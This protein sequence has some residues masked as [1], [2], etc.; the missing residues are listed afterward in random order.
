MDAARRAT[1]VKRGLAGSVPPT[2]KVT[3]RIHRHGGGLLKERQVKRIRL[4]RG[5]AIV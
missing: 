1:A 3:G 2:K 4:A 5:E